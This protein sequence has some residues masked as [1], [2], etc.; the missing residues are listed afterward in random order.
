MQAA[1]KGSYDNMP[2]LASTLSQLSKYQPEFV[3]SLVDNVLEDM[4]HHLVAP[5]ITTRQKQLA[6]ARMLA[7]LYNHKVIRHQLLFYALYMQITCGMFLTA[8]GALCR[9]CY[10]ELCQQSI[11]TQ[12]SIEWMPHASCA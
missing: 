1:V 8:R 12:F 4:H 6:H 5:L 3:N 11:G 7:E 9:H 10:H 2:A